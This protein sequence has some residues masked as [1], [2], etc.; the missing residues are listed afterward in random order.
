MAKLTLADVTNILGNPTSAAN[1]LN[2]NNTLVEVALEKT[3]SRDGT[4]PNQMLADLDMNNNDILNVKSLETGSLILNGQVVTPDELLTLPESVMIKPTYD[5][6]GVEG[7]AFNRLNFHT[8]DGRADYETQAVFAALPSVPVGVNAIRIRG[9]YTAGD[10]G[11]HQKRR[12]SA[13]VTVQPY[14]TV[15]ADGSM[16][17]ISENQMDLR[18]FGA[19]AEVA[20]DNRDI[21]RAAIRAASTLVRK[22]WVRGGVFEVAGSL[23]VESNLTMEWDMGSWLKMSA[24]S[25]TGAF[26]TNV[27]GA[28]VPGNVVSNITLINPQIDLEPITYLPSGN[29]TNSENGIGFARNASY[30]TIWGGHIKNVL[31]NFLIASGGVGGKGIGIDGGVHHVTV[32]GTRVENT[33]YGIWV[34]GHEGTFGGIDGTEQTFGVKFI[35]MHFEDVQLPISLMGRDATEDPDR[36]MADFEVQV[37]ST[38][39]HNC[40]FAPTVRASSLNRYKSGII[41]L[42]EAQ[43]FLVDGVH[44]YNDP[45]Y[46]ADNGGWPVAGNYIGQGL[47]GPIGAVIYGWGSA[48]TVQNVTHGGDVDHVWVCGRNFAMGDDASP[49]QRVVNTRTLIDNIRVNGAVSTVMRQ[50]NFAGV[51]SSAALTGQ[52]SRIYP[53]TLTNLISSNAASLTQLYIQVY[54]SATA[55]F[56]EGNPPFLFT[57]L[58][59]VLNVD[60][61]GWMNDLR[62]HK[63]SSYAPLVI[64]DNATVSLALNKTF[65]VMAFSSDISLARG[66]FQYRSTASPQCGVLGAAISNVTF[67]TGASPAGSAGQLTISVDTVGNL[68][69]NNQRGSSVTLDLNNLA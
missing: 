8:D 5:P 10:G 37:L 39:Y 23:F 32:F 66:V 1:T 29:T 19:K 57:T 42:G 59:N 62:I 56:V 60:V 16:W 31:A 58:G 50:D 2:S 44:G 51:L 53:E 17:E 13:P 68:W 64:A 48:G 45:T 18:Q 20:F 36:E 61:Q 55:R 43:N 69:V 47:S 25:G 33:F 65:G 11:G 46:I 34:R 14:H 7:D 38:T 26:F 21:I 24:Y 49:T 12:L 63:P 40:G 52:M 67:T 30:I 15:L 4:S 27:E 41:N 28:N 6:T 35:G 3:L 22:L 54:N 9:Y